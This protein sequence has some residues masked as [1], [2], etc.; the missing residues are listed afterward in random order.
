MHSIKFKVGAICILVALI[1]LVIP[2]SADPVIFPGY[3]I[4]GTKWYYGTTAPTEDIGMVD[5]YYLEISN[6]AIYH[7]EPTW[8]SLFNIMGATGAPGAAN[9]TAN[10]TAGPTGDPGA[11]N[12]TANMTAGPTGAPG[13]ANMTANMTA[14]ATGA[15]GAA[16]LT[17]NMTA[18]MT[19]G[20]PGA[21]NM[22][23][24]MTSNMTQGEKGDVGGTAGKV[25]YMRNSSAAD[26][27][28]YG[29]LITQ[30]SGNPEVDFTGTI[31]Q[32]NG[33]VLIR[34]YVT[35]L[36]YPAVAEI[37][38]G[39]WVFHEYYY[40][41]SSLSATT[42]VYD[43]YNRTATGTETLLFTATSGD[44]DAT[45]TQAYDTYYTQSTPYYISTSDRIVVKVSIQTTRVASTTYHRFTDGTTHNAYIQT[46]LTSVS[47]NS[48]V[49]NALSGSNALYRGQA[50]YISAASGGVPV[51][52][53]V[54]NTITA[55]TRAVGLVTDSVGANTNTNFIRVGALTNVDTRPTNTALNPLGQT[56]AAGDLLFAATSGGLT[57][58]RPTSG[59]S[60]KCAY[61]MGGSGQY[62]TLL[63]YPFENP[64]WSTAAS[65]ED[66]VLRM[67]D[68]IG[69]N[70]VS[71]RNYSN[72]EVGYILSN[73]TSS[74]GSGIGS[75]NMTAN[76]TAGPAGSPGAANMTANM[77][78]GATGATGAA[79]LTPNMTANLTAGPAGS[80]GAANMT[81]NMTAGA[82][83]ATGAANLTP[84]MTANLTAGP[85]GGA[86]DS[87]GFL[88]LNG[89]RQ[90]M[91]NLDIGKFK[92]FN[93][94][95]SSGVDVTNKT[96][97][98]SV[99]N[100]PNLSSI[101]PIGSVYITTTSTNPNTLF[102]GFGTWNPLG[103]GY[104]LV[105]V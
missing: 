94:T 69:V 31:Q 57:N 68:N 15:T 11:A 77:T 23:A 18:N 33:K 24:N 19:A 63:A 46:P 5:D 76:M 48:L 14:G 79:N 12:M 36:G 6:G 98:D 89:T 103:N 41:S 59:R 102:E 84:N 40:L 44:I 27:T 25:L 90:M 3:N 60:V 78:A 26:P 73:G 75:A 35:E 65:G 4:I 45:S 47:A 99:Y 67:G 13:A 61:D 17:A 72:S 80:P 7:K 16:N 82:T 20:A 100:R 81:A 2:V 91:G 56:W 52:D 50:V 32:A 95:S 10:M 101:Y 93:S 8:V 74:F 39:L 96:Y 21:N 22:T 85:P 58:V 62:D 42:F 28:T 87:T 83:G 49:I 71:F 30:P 88:F 55:K 70:K 38:A 43:V 64:V 54:D 9:M 34:S 66:I 37:P 86:G 29:G 105:G 53:L 1:A 97:V 104:V 92:I 51:I